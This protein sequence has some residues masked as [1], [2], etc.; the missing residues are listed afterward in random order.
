MMLC[1]EYKLEVWAN[2]FYFKTREKAEG[3]R[4][5]LNLPVWTLA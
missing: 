2:E 1:F 4:S 5:N 3:Q